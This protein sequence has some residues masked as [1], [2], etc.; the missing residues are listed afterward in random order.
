[1]RMLKLR[2]EDGAVLVHTAIAIVAL[3]G[4]AALSIDYGVLWVARRQAQNAADSAALAAAISLAFGDPSDTDRIRAVAEG[5]GETNLV[6]GEAPEIDPATDVTIGPCPPNTPGDPDLCVKVDVYRNQARGNALPTFLANLVGVSEQG[7]RASATAQV[8][9]GAKATCV[10]PWAIPDKW[11]ELTPT[12]SPWDLNDTFDRY[13]TTGNPSKWTLLSPADYYVP[14]SAGSAGSGFT[15]PGDVGMRVRLKV[16]N[17]KD[18]DI[19]PGN[20]RAVV[21]PGGCGS[22]GGST[23]ECNIATCN[24]TPLGIGDVIE[25]EPGVMVGPTTHGLDT[26]IGGDTTYWECANGS[27][28]SPTQDCF[29]APSASGSPR[30]VPVPA[31]NV[32]K[33]MEDAVAGLTKPNGRTDV[34]VTRILGFFIEGWDSK[35]IWGRFTYYPDSG[36]ITNGAV[37]ENAN[38][39]RKVILVR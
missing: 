38:F 15:V 25:T 5:V 3:L 30:L 6:W 16:E 2:E 39:L 4:F 9:Q 18:S 17:W 27:P 7:V 23:Y 36:G 20:V 34:T 37:D 35:E 31:F 14:P 32:Q 33:Y 28:A 29:G 19:G 21:L 1:M 11:S 13:D 10:K 22:S 12:S 24:P 8:A 26:L